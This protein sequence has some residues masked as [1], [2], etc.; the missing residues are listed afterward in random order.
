MSYDIQWFVVVVI[1]FVLCISSVAARKA[2]KRQKRDAA[3]QQQHFAHV[4]QQQ[5]QRPVALSHDVHTLLQS[6][7]LSQF[8][9]V[10]LC[11]DNSCGC[12]FAFCDTFTVTLLCSNLDEVRAAIADQGPYAPTQVS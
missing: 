2:I 8:R 6:I 4:E 3:I 9:F 12:L 5:A 11:L 1:F 10:L 7:D